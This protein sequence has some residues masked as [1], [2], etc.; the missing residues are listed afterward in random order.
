[1]YHYVRHFKHGRYPDIKGMDYAH[2]KEQ[3]SYLNKHYQFITMEM[4]IDAI[5][6]NTALPEKAV[7][8]T[9]DDGYMEHFNVVFPLLNELKIQGSFFPPVKAITHHIVLDTNKIH[10]ILA[11][12]K[13][14]LK[15]IK[16]IKIELDKYRKD[17]NLESDSY[18][19]DKLAHPSRYDP[20]DIVF[21]K[22]LL[23]VELDET[24]RSKITNDLFEKIVDK[25]EESFSRELY[26]DM[27]QIKCMHRNGMHIGSHGYNHYWLGTQ[28]QET[29][30]M[31][32][33][34]SL[35]FLNQIG[36]DT[37][38]WTMSYP[39]GNYNSSTI[40]LLKANN[41]KLAFTT[42]VNIAN[43][44][45]YDKYTLPRL[46]ANDIPANSQAIKNEWYFKG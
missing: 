32:I 23:Q 45:Q 46:D 36:C 6:H 27:E 39:Y 24:V 8:L 13:D 28:T 25:N 19:Y 11:A 5:D 14:K 43:L 40:E 7:L 21:I 16:E 17:Y 20:A 2:F 12:E 22:R 15:I 38:N 31:E 33:E 18:Y 37:N 10:F 44:E 34:K 30:K 41:C 3:I 29:Q 9:F 35:V 1:M 26:M 42:E 4:L